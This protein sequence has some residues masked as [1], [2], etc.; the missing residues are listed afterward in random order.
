MLDKISSLMH[1]KLIKNQSHQINKK[2]K[3]WCRNNVQS[4]SKHILSFY[5]IGFQFDEGS[6]QEDFNC[7]KVHLKI[8]T[9]T[10]DVS[11]P[12]PQGTRSPR[13][14]W[15]APC[16]AS[17][18]RVEARHAAHAL[19]PPAPHVCG[20]IC[21]PLTSSAIIKLLR[22]KWFSSALHLDNGSFPHINSSGEIA[23][24][25]LDAIFKDFYYF[26]EVIWGKFQL[27]R[28]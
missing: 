24:A 27:K 12:R 10:Y 8:M 26:Q 17:R 16:S 22:P 28:F 25:T 7:T 23:P 2:K 9:R 18:Q 13:L 4:C 11:R 15:H 21:L 1:F 5:I 3:T 20:R 6:T 14:C 19:K